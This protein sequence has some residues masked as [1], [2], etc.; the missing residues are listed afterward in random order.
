MIDVARRAAALDDLQE[1]PERDQLLELLLELGAGDLACRRAARRTRDS[2]A[3][4]ISSVSSSRSSRM[5]VSLR[6]RLARKS[7]GCAM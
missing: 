1:L 3:R 5:K 4:R 6:P 7:G 2:T